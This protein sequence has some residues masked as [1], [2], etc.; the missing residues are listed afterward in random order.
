M[1]MRIVVGM[2]R[3]I[4][5]FVTHV[6]I[7]RN[8]APFWITTSISIESNFSQDFVNKTHTL[9]KEWPDIK[10]SF[11]IDRRFVSELKWNFVPKYENF[12]LLWNLDLLW[13]WQPEDTPIVRRPRR[14]VFSGLLSSTSNYGVPGNFLMISILPTRFCTVCYQKTNLQESQFHQTCNTIRRLQ[15]LHFSFEEDISSLLALTLWN[16]RKPSSGTS[17]LFIILQKL[18]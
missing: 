9:G 10:Y 4:I 5:S 18:F 17:S 8:C 12:N 6:K 16:K 7:W 1:N 13:K 11:L 14:S 2:H 3:I 15:I